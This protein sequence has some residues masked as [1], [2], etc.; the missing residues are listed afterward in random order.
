MKLYGTLALA[1]ALSF[2]VGNA[3]VGSCQSC[4]AAY[5]LYK[6]KKYTQSE[7]SYKQVLSKHPESAE[8]LYGIGL[9][10]LC[11]GHFEQAL[12][13]L[14]KSISIEETAKALAAR[15]DCFYDMD[16]FY[17]ARLDFRRCIEIDPK[18]PSYQRSLGQ[19]ALEDQDEVESIIAFSMA[20][21]LEP[22][23][24]NYSRRAEAQRVM[25]RYSDA[26][27][28][29]ARAI[30]IDPKDPSVYQARAMIQ[31]DLKKKDEALEDID[32]AVKL[33]EKNPDP[34]IYRDQSTILRW[35]EKYTEAEQACDKA[36]KYA[37][38]RDV[39]KL[40]IR[41][42]SCKFNNDEYVDALKDMDE[43]IRLA[44]QRSRPY[45]YRADILMSLKRFDDADRDLQKWMDLRYSSD[46][47]SAITKSP[48]KLWGLACSAILFEKNE[49]DNVT[50]AGQ[51][52]TK[53]CKARAKK[54][55]SDVWKIYT[56]A[57]Y[58][59]T[60]SNFLRTDDHVQ[61]SRLAKVVETMTPAEQTDFEKE[62]TNKAQAYK[63][64]I[65]KQ[66]YKEV[67]PTGLLGWDLAR[68]INCTRMAY[69]AGLIEEDEAWARIFNVAIRIQDNYN[70]WKDVGYS[71]LV[72]RK[73]W[74]ESR[75]EEAGDDFDRAYERLTQL[76][77]SPYKKCQWSL[78]LK[79]AFQDAVR[80]CIKNCHSQYIADIRAA[81]GVPLQISTADQLKS[82]VEATP[83]PVPRKLRSLLA[84]SESEFVN[85]LT[86][87][88]AFGP[89]KFNF[90]VPLM[91]AL[92]E[93][94][95]AT[96]DRTTVIATA[97]YRFENDDKCD[98]AALLR[99][100]KQ[101]AAKAEN[102][103][104]LNILAETEAEVKVRR[105]MLGWKTFSSD[106]FGGA[107]KLPS[108]ESPSIG[109]TPIL[110]AANFGKGVLLISDETSQT[111]GGQSVTA[112]RQTLGLLL[113]DPSKKS[114]NRIALGT[115]DSIACAVVVNETLYAQCRT[116]SG[117]VLLAVEA[118]SQHSRT[119]SIPEQEEG[120]ILGCTQNSVILV[121]NS[122]VQVLDKD[123][124][125]TVYSST[126]SLKPNA[127]K[128]ASLL[129][130]RLYFLDDEE[131]VAW[132]DLA[133]HCKKHRLNDELKKL[134]LPNLLFQYEYLRP[135]WM[136][137]VDN[138]I[139]ASCGSPL[140]SLV[141]V[142]GDGSIQFALYAGRTRVD[143]MENYLTA[144]KSPNV[145]VE[146]NAISRSGA[147]LIIIGNNGLYRVRDSKINLI[148]TRDYF[149][150]LKMHKPPDSA[151][152]SLTPV[153]ASYRPVLHERSI[154]TI[155]DDAYVM[156]TSSG[157]ILF[158]KQ[159]VRIEMNAESV[160]RL[161]EHLEWQAE[162]LKPSDE[163]LHW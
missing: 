17:G 97:I 109:H 55:F 78:P 77:S 141:Q 23:A 5:K 95:I 49:Q 157:P 87:G 136:R 63:F 143:P 117:L 45:A 128:G 42:A 62:L 102:E 11:L 21:K 27:E 53:A 15:G 145:Y 26:L 147:D 84:N 108:P 72:G 70:S 75:S 6:D 125:E 152:I 69:A 13:F 151:I 162:Y 52:L 92:T 134:N 118:T 148:A 9:N 89:Q 59:K 93:E 96:G 106:D 153:S 64:R 160:D 8:A 101:K 139:W 60:Y 111:P 37:E 79:S 74:S 94:G 41:R 127:L 39:S 124:W 51:P 31:K 122:K 116:K 68:A 81:S 2:F 61:F 65:V 48:E 50:L 58:V 34:D 24:K 80:T 40:L 71:Y 56:R 46:T 133:D 32:R 158:S 98:Y 29:C 129:N 35:L 135:Q 43:A 22:S 119:I 38:P 19:S 99:E 120:T 161:A 33:A 82:Y 44:P 163:V 114:L 154:N 28:D 85:I 110:N 103:R 150:S 67:G 138:K 130:R 112:A 47:A 155:S 104:F 115:T 7:D 4:A 156:G 132:L 144:S 107:Y 105:S 25:K 12:D 83:S 86:K 66:Y 1:F 30:A 90:P 54:S 20:I 73:F 137:L 76:S 131:Q 126:D 10:E 113:F 123:K 18:N 91:S 88:F 57:D 140:Q 149:R 3:S 142:T 100:Y 16:R 36:I 14:N 146:S 159:Q 121:S